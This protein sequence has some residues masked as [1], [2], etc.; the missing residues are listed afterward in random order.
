MDRR[1]GHATLLAAT[2]VALAACS[3]FT[4]P[5]ECRAGESAPC[6]SPCG[7]GTITCQRD[8]TWGA[9]E[10]PGSVECMPGEYGT[11]PGRE[12]EPPGLWL[13][14]DTCRVGPCLALC[15]P[16]EVFRD[17]QAGC[18]PGTSTCQDDG[19]WGPCMEYVIPECRPGD[20]AA[21]PDESGHRRCDDRCIWDD[22]HDG[23]CAPGE[24]SRCGSCA[25]QVCLTDGSWSAC[26]ADDTAVCSPGEVEACEAPCGPGQ[27]LCDEHCTWTPCME[28]VDVECH[29]G[30]RQMC[31]TTLYCGLAYRLCSNSC[32]WMDCIETGD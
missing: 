5:D 11:C 4:G 30:Q 8:G 25:S 29:P 6:E 28:L 26:A 2:L 1:I 22:C 15:I 12:G 20:I 3:G 27:R 14:S 10:I 31:P 18:G 19:S 21:C 13:C 24:I 32:R 17:C 16:G 7:P 9:C 23:P